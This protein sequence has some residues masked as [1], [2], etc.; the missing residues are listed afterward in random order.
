LLS[1]E[2]VAREF[3]AL[4][5][6]KLLGTHRSRDVLIDSTGLKSSI[7]MPLASFSN[8]GGKTMIGTRVIFIYDCK[9]NLPLFYRYISG[10]ITDVTTLRTT[11][12]K[13]K[14]LNVDI[15]SIIMDAGYFSEKN[16]RFLIMFK[17]KFLTRLRSN[18][19]LYKDMIQEYA[20]IIE[21]PENRIYYKDRLLFCVRVKTD[22]VKGKEGYVYVVLDAEKRARDILN[23]NSTD[24]KSRK[25]DED[26][27]YSRKACGIFMLVS[28]EC[29]EIIKIL[30]Y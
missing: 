3:Y 7:K 4:Y 14:G 20:D 28:S 22:I 15:A 29:V 13:L 30:P 11:I 17:I 27:T 25:S 8:H 5:F 10:N 2:E 9:T 1:T 6:D 21:R 18:Y 16:I 12:S 19:K 26:Y 23:L 24:S